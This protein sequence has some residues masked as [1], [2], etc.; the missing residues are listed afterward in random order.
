MDNTF[1]ISFILSSLIEKRIAPNFKKVNCEISEHK[2]SYPTLGLFGILMLVLIYM[3]IPGLPGSGILLDNTAVRYI[4]KLFGASS[5]FSNG[6]ICIFSGILGICGLFYG[7]L[8]GIKNSSVYS[9]G[10]SK[11]FD[12]LGYLF[13]LM[14]FISQLEGLIE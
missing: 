2:F 6:F 9:K 1:I 11:M 10:I 13:V 14:F 3:I 4:D 7:Y 8:N 5:P 12:G